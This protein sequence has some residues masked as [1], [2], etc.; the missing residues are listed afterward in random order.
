MKILVDK[1]PKTADE[2]PFSTWYAGKRIC[3]IRKTIDEG[4]VWI[5]PLTNHEDCTY[6]R[7][8]GE[9]KEKNAELKQAIRTIR[10]ECRK[11]GDCYGCPFSECYPRKGN[12]L[13]MTWSDNPSGWST[14]DMIREKENE[15]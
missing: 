10:D 6:L 14:W 9:V 12:C 4:S 15:C 8:T 5:C 13:V 11:H 3:S 1:I 7:G 2:C